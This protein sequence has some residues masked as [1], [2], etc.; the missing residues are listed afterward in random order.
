[1]W[2]PEANREQDTVIMETLIASGRLTNKELKDINYCHIYLQAFFISDI[3]N[4]EGNR[5]EEW[6]GCGKKQVGYQSLWEC[7]IQQRPIAWK[8]WRTALEYLAPD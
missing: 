6:V 5:I 3:T 1:L 7:P 8:A 2:Q 4:L